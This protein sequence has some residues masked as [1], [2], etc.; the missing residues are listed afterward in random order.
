[1]VLWFGEL[2]FAGKLQ[3]K[4]LRSLDAELPFFISTD[5]Q[6]RTLNFF[7]LSLHCHG[8]MDFE[9]PGFWFTATSNRMPFLANVVNLHFMFFRLWFSPEALRANFI[10]VTSFLRKVSYLVHT[11]A[12]RRLAVGVSL[13]RQELEDRVKQLQYCIARSWALIDRVEEQIRSIGLQLGR[14]QEELLPDRRY[15]WTELVAVWIFGILRLLAFCREKLL[16]D[17]ATSESIGDLVGDQQKVEL[18]DE[19]S[20]IFNFVCGQFTSTFRCEESW[21]KLT[22]EFRTAEVL[23][24]VSDLNFGRWWSKTSLRFLCMRE[25]WLFM[26]TC[27][28][29][30]FKVWRFNFRYYAQVFVSLQLW[31]FEW[32]FIER[33]FQAQW[34][35]TSNAAWILHLWAQL[36]RKTSSPFSTFLHWRKLQVDVQV[37]FICQDLQLQNSFQVFLRHFSWF[38]LSILTQCLICSWTSQ[39]QQ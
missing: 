6:L 8:R 3:L 9:L 34:F 18:W 10:N 39:H 16:K 36:W 31:T 13:S 28:T 12:G 24:Y 22:G 5:I 30:Q 37:N 29:L 17:L 19:S 11:A 35:E 27:V 1:M 7:F 15:N 23:W 38:D 2:R 25:G 4:T 21:W 32:N 33:R 20:D 26:F 14:A